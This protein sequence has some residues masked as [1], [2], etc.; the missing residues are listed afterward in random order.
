MISKHAL[1]MKNGMKYILHY[2][3][4]K[5][6]KKKYLVGLYTPLRDFY[7]TDILFLFWDEMLSVLEKMEAEQV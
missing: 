2:Y 6:Y 3:D 4:T 7:K 1:E 5:G